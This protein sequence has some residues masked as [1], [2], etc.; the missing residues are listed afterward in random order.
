[1]HWQGVRHSFRRHHADIASG[2]IMRIIGKLSHPVACHPAF[3][4]GQW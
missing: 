1:M 2:D 4:F 3:N